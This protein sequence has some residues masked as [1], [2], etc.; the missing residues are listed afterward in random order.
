MEDE[1]GSV[2][3][4]TPQG[5]E[6]ITLWIMW[7][8]IISENHQFASFSSLLMRRHPRGY[9]LQ[10]SLRFLRLYSS[11]LLWMREA[12][13]EKWKTCTHQVCTEAWH[14]L[15]KPPGFVEAEVDTE[16]RRDEKSMLPRSKRSSLFLIECFQ[17]YKLNSHGKLFSILICNPFG[18]IHF[19]NSER[20]FYNWD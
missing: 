9:Q 15:W 8:H 5:M 7:G 6:N 20:Y 11:Q 17:V 1:G 12:R 16:T 4:K 14:Y 18:Q 2:S 13:A 19:D 10:V 3:P